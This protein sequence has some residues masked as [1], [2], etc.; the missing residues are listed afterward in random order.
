MTAEAARIADQLANARSGRS[1]DLPGV[2]GLLGVPGFIYVNELL[3]EAEPLAR[4]LTSVRP[5]RFVL[6]ASEVPDELHAALAAAGWSFRRT[7]EMM[8]LPRECVP[9][10]PPDGGNV[11][12]EPIDAANVGDVKPL[13]DLAFG[14]R[15]HPSAFVAD[16]GTRGFLARDRSGEVVAMAGWAAAGLG[17]KIFS[18]ATHP[19]HRRQ[20][21]GTLMTLEAVHSAHR[22]GA[23]FCYL[24]STTSGAGVYRRVGFRTLD[25]WHAYR[26]PHLQPPSA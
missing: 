9:P 2:I 24:E 19:G 15:S 13:S 6:V 3:V 25:T 5:P 23:R 26:H 14:L 18:V 17:A 1:I 11:T 7:L 22:S 20:G 8:I 21:L 4:Y 12:V 16:P 10:R